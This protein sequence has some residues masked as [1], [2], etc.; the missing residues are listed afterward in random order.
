MYLIDLH[1]D[2]FNKMYETGLRDFAHNG[3]GIDIEKLIKADSL[4]QCMTIYNLLYKDGYSFSELKK[5]HRFFMDI[6]NS[7]PQQLYL[8]KKFSDIDKTDN[9]GRLNIMMTIEDAGPVDGDLS[10]IRQLYDMGVRLLTLTWNHENCFGFPNSKNSVVNEKGLKQ[11]GYDAIELMNEIGMIIDVAHLS[12]GGIRDVTDASKKPVTASHTN[13]R[14]INEHP[15]NLSDELVRRIA[16]GGGLIGVAV[17]PH[18]IGPAFESATVGSWLHHIDRIIDIGGIDCLAIGTDFDG[19]KIGDAFEIKNIG[20][21]DILLH[22]LRKSGHGETDIE[23]IF[24]KNALRF[25]G[26]LR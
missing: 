18:F 22:A 10:R 19:T 9:A 16:E 12:D 17:E 2:T 20:Q 23:K 24:F 8:V 15:R 21:M 7:Y 3:L 26:D 13:A 14:S 5:Q 6:M 1:S 11:F 4:V 25:L